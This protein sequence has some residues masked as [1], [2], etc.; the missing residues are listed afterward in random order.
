VNIF[1]RVIMILSILSLFILATI[2]LIIPEESLLVLNGLIDASLHTYS[3]IRPE[4]ILP[5]RALLALCALLFDLLLIGLLLLEVRAPAR[6]TLRVAQVGGGSV[7]LTAE[8]LTERVRYH[9]DQIA[10]VIGV[11]VQATPKRG[12]VD[13]DIY[14]STGADANVP[15]KAEEVLETTRQVVEDKLGNLQVRKDSLCHA[16]HSLLVRGVRRGRP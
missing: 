15:H 6:R 3:R 5:F 16:M 11:K 10:G 14:I 7:S 8:S 9:I 13:L 2:V 4:F 1:N 12:G